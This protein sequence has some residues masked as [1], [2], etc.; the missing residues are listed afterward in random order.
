MD[1]RRIINE[2]QNIPY[3][4]RNIARS[5]DEAFP[6]LTAKIK[7][8]WRCNLRCRFCGLWRYSE[9]NDGP[10]AITLEL[11]KSI[12]TVL[13]GR[14]LRKIHFS[15]GEVT[16]REDLEEIVRFACG[17]GLQVNLTT[18]GTLVDKRTARFLVEHRVHT[19]V[20]SVDEARPRRHDALRGVAGAWKRTW[21]GIR[22][23]Q[24]RREAKGRGPKIAVNTVL[25]RHNIDHLPDLFEMLQDNG[26]DSWRLLP[27][28]TADPEMRPT[29]EQWARLGPR[30]S[31]WAPL[32]GRRILDLTC[33]GNPELAAK[34]LYADRGEALTCLAPWFSVFVDADGNVL[35]CCTGRKRIPAYGNVTR[36][37]LEAILSSRIRREL[38]AS[39]ASGHLFEVCRSCDEFLQENSLLSAAA[40]FASDSRA[41]PQTLPRSPGE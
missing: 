2:N 10:D 29:A 34:G 30:I 33:A 12:L 40:V 24:A 14:G 32:V 41:G 26:I 7:L 5:P 23:M 20:F 25:T 38:C 6:T 1:I 37:P 31:R 17:L 27:V 9:A 18:N 8:T 28:R 16:L 21:R 3:M 4:V 13:A 36:Q 35:P 15:G 39:F 11:V 19:V 22:R